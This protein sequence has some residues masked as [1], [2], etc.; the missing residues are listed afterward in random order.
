MEGPQHQAGADAGAAEP[1]ALL[2]WSEALAGIA[3]TGLA[4]TESLYEQERYREVLSVAGD[5]RAAADRAQSSDGHERL[6]RPEAV[7]RW[8]ADAGEGIAGYATPKVAIGAVVGNGEGKLLLVQR[9]DSGAWL[10]PTGW[11][12]IGYSA[13]EIAAKEVAEETGIIVE[14]LRLIMVF[15]GLRLGA[16]G[17]P[18]YS[19]VFHCRAVGGSL[20][21]H[22]LECMDAGWFAEQELPTPLAGATAWRE[23]AFRALRG[24]L[25]A[26]W[27]D[28]PRR[29]PWRVPHTGRDGDA[30]A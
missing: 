7:R 23:P 4:F 19:L 8:L 22:P 17:T 1:A 14:P 3:R 30:G 21:P 27:F 26:V 18:F 25:D 28:A 12:D 2:R 16:S 29:P 15:D 6:D 24:E 20:V 13:A 11:A 5:I 9:A 10:Y